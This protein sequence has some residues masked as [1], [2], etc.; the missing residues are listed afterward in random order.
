MPFHPKHV[1]IT[2]IALLHMAPLAQAQ[3]SSADTAP[4]TLII[5]RPTDPFVVLPEFGYAGSTLG[6]LMEHASEYANRN[7]RLTEKATGFPSEI[8]S[9][10][11][12]REDLNGLDVAM[13]SEEFAQILDASY[14]HASETY[15]WAN[16]DQ[17]VSM[18]IAPELPEG[19][20]NYREITRANHFVKKT[21]R[22]K[23]TAKV[24]ANPWLVSG[25]GQ[26]SLYTRLE[27][28]RN[29]SNPDLPKNYFASVIVYSKPLGEA[30]AGEWFADDLALYRTFMRCATAETMHI[31]RQAM[32]GNLKEGKGR[33]RRLSKAF[34]SDT[35][36]KRLEYAAAYHPI[37]Q[38]GHRVRLAYEKKYFG[39]VIPDAQDYRKE[40]PSIASGPGLAECRAEPGAEQAIAT[41][42]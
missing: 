11:T 16:I 5:E 4:L 23:M 21:I 15:L 3:T 34:F 25:A 28:R 22:N 27:F 13:F 2:V 14:Q 36:Q 12:L 42:K 19:R 7:L 35:G 38:S 8:Q 26:I 40:G 9:V 18:Q 31:F 17:T 32:E 6:L 20:P 41:T 39:S 30:R 37:E 29:K 10:S 33:E 1:A 24:F